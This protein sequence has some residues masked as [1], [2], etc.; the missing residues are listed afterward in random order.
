MPRAWIPARCRKNPPKR[1][2]SSKIAS[3]KS[4]AQAPL[5]ICRSNAHAPLNCFN[6]VIQSQGIIGVRRMS[7]SELQVAYQADDDGTGKI[8]ATVKSG[9]FSARGAAWVNPIDVKRTFVAALRSFP[10]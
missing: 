9:E 6:A 8:I 7:A 2:K 5:F 4:G 10:L 1:R 3:F